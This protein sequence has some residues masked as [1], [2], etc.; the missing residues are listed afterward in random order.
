MSVC[1]QESL[2]KQTQYAQSLSE[3]LWHAERQLEELEI[4]KDTKDKKRSELTGTILRLET[5][6]LHSL[7]S[8]AAVLQQ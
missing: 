7:S 5:E 6:V 3:K 4:D 2:E 1:A 8:P